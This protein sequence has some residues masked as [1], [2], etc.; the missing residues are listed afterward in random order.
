MH[1]LVIEFEAEVSG[2]KLLILAY[3]DVVMDCD[4]AAEGLHAHIDD[5]KIISARDEEQCVL[6]T[7]AQIKVLEIEAEFETYKQLQGAL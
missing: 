2:R 1:D 6:L 3:V 5:V 7:E 4:C